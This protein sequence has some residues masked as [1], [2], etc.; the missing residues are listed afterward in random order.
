M[1]PCV[2]SSS[3]SF[4]FSEMFRH[5]A[6]DIRDLMVHCSC[7]C[8]CVCVCGVYAVCIRG[9]CVSIS[10]YLLAFSKKAGLVLVQ[11]PFGTAASLC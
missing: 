2:S 10:G 9:V 4:S 5:A 11:D 7:V 1:S 3:L 6:L 8:V